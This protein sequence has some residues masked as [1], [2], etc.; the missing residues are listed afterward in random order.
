MCKGW[1]PPRRGAQLPGHPEDW[2]EDGVAAGSGR[3]GSPRGG[4]GGG[5]AEGWEALSSVDLP[6]LPAHPGGGRSPAAS[7]PPSTRAS[8]CNLPEA[9]RSEPQLIGGSVQ[10]PHGSASAVHLASRPGP[11]P[12]PAPWLFGPEWTDLLLPSRG[13]LSSVTPTDSDLGSGRHPAR[14]GSG[15]RSWPLPFP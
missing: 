10:Q 11:L 7:R 9:R 12:R 3:S 15:A 13:P 14:R 4:G 5:G 2:Q 8:G 6:R 1:W